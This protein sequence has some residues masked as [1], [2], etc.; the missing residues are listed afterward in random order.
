MEKTLRIKLL[1]VLLAATFIASSATAG[2]MPIPAGTKTQVAGIANSPLGSL[3]VVDSYVYQYSTGAHANQYLYTYEL[4][5]TSIGI[6]F[7]SVGV[8]DA[9]NLTLNVANVNY[10]GAG[11]APTNWRPAGGPIQSVDAGFFVTPIYSGQTSA[12]LW[13]VCD[14]APVMGL[15]SIFGTTSGVPSFAAGQLYT[16]EVPEP[17][18]IAMLTT[19]ALWSFIRRKKR[20]V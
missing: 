8:N 7:F 3:G 4:T 6:S 1:I 11:V 17:A 20:N 16:M 13:I 15:G 14:Y 2:L 10:A 9:A 19:G 12:L 18:T 5:S